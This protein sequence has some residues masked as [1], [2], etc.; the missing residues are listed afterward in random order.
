MLDVVGPSPMVRGPRPPAR[1]DCARRGQSARR[2]AP[3]VALAACACM[4][5]AKCGVAAPAPARSWATSARRDR[6]NYAFY[7]CQPPLHGIGPGRAR[8]VPVRRPFPAVRRSSVGAAPAAALRRAACEAA[9]STATPEG[10]R[11]PSCC[12]H[13]RRSAHGTHGERAPET[14]TGPTC[15]SRRVT[16]RQRTCIHITRAATARQNSDMWARAHPRR[17]HAQRKTSRAASARSPRS[18][19]NASPAST[20]HARRG[21]SIRAHGDSWHDGMCVWL[22]PIW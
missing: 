3:R 16:D 9:T 20:L 13:T 18:P 14:R 5:K 6:E 17:W 21:T 10:T 4:V 11:D 15:R 8:R 12:A 2:V 22:C 19:T 7:H 1:R